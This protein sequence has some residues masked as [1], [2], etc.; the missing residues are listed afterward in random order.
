MDMACPYSA[1]FWHYTDFDNFC[2][3][4]CLEIFKFLIHIRKDLVFF[5]FPHPLSPVLSPG[6]RI[7]P[8]FHFYNESPTGILPSF[9][10]KNRHAFSLLFYK[11]HA[12]PKRFSRRKKACVRHDGRNKL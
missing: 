4:F 1:S 8:V 2:K 10:K 9:E 7:G 11:T 3:G 6:P 12:H 5:M